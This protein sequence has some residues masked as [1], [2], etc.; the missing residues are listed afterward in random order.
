MQAHRARRSL[1]LL[2]NNASNHSDGP[3]LERKMREV[4]HR[5]EVA[6]NHCISALGDAAHPYRNSGRCQQRDYSPCR[7]QVCRSRSRHRQRE[8]AVGG[9]EVERGRGGRVS[10]KVCEVKESGGT[11]WCRLVCLGLISISFCPIYC[12][13]FCLIAVWMSRVL[14]PQ[15][16]D[17]RLRAF[18]EGGPWL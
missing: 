11:A 12:L 9:G 3:H 8:S 18:S 7:D 13:R 2:L 6:G 1:E 4:A 5:I 16:R 14:V 15:E 17:G 10:W